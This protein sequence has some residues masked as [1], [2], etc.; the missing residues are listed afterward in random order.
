MESSRKLLTLFQIL[1]IL[2]VATALTVNALANALP[3][4]G[5]TTG[6]LS[7]QYP[8]L[9][10]PAGVTFSIWGLIYLLW[11]TLIL[12]QA[13]TLLSYRKAPV[14]E[15]IG[16]RFF[17]NM[18]GNAA[19]LVAW[20]YERVGISV[21]IMLFLLGSLLVLYG[22]L[23][24][25]ERAV[26]RGE[27]YFVHLP[28][29]VYLGWITVATIANITALLVDVGWDGFGLG[30]QL[31]TIVLIGVA[32]GI[33]LLMIQARRDVAFS[34]VV[35]WALLGIL[36]RRL[37]T[38]PDPL[39]PVLITAILGIGIVLIALVSMRDASRRAEVSAL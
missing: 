31:W 10:V 14:V 13:R 19:W 36:I 30:A 12:Y 34:G 18:L 27:R 16:P 29:S 21:A 7:D 37:S 28:I 2:G 33:T 17:L 22:R 8:N 5:R 3:I 39:Y 1:N 25:G 20:H 26:S 15:R 23:G 24:V 32:V 9:F 6:E 35:V 4:N 11:I 38:D